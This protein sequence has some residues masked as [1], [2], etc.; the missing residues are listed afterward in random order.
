MR[1]Q[2]MKSS[3]PQCYI[4]SETELESILAH[5]GNINP[6]LIIIDSIQIYNNQYARVFC[7]TRISQGQGVCRAASEVFKK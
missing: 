3:N 7:Q 4:L 2:R 6:G 1:A 5:A